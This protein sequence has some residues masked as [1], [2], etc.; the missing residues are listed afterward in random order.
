MLLGPFTQLKARAD[1][2]RPSRPSPCRGVSA[3]LDRKRRPSISGGRRSMDQGSSPPTEHQLRELRR[4]MDIAMG[5]A[6][7]EE[8]GV[9]EAEGSDEVRPGRRGR[10]GVWA[11]DARWLFCS[12]EARGQSCW[13][14]STPWPSRCRI[15]PDVDAQHGVEGI[16]ERS[17][18]KLS[19]SSE[20]KRSSSLFFLFLFLFCF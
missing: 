18:R 8:G 13:S 14:A 19:G 20:E 15:L 6:V 12:P 17:A 16:W 1:P 10:V 9:S 5:A 4:A 3:L 2:L 7:S 11:C